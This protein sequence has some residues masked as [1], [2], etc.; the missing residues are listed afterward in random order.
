MQTFRIL[1]GVQTFILSSETLE[2]NLEDFLLTTGVSNLFIK[3]SL[4]LPSFALF[5]GDG[6]SSG[7]MEGSI[8]VGVIFLKG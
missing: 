8:T 1:C 4:I 7:I 2:D 5:G 6:P 3:D